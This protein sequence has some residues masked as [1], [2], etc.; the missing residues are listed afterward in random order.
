MPR[1]N[2][3]K[4]ELAECNGMA[5]NTFFSFEEEDGVV[6]KWVGIKSVRSTCARCPIWSQCASYA[7]ENEKFGIWGGLSSR[8]R[9]AF[10]KKGNST[11]RDKAI[12]ELVSL[13]ISWQEI[14]KAIKNGK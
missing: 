13:G 12:G 14:R 4:W 9:K 2:E 11:L 8:E 3:I 7:I 1:F 10:R 6:E 5:P